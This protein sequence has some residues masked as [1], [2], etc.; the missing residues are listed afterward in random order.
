MSVVLANCGEALETDAGNDTSPKPD[1][2]SHSEST[3][4]PEAGLKRLSLPVAD[5]SAL[6]MPD[7]QCS[8]SLTLDANHVVAVCHAE[9]LDTESDYGPRLILVR[10]PDNSPTLLFHSEGGGDAYGANLAV[11]GQ[12]SNSEIHIIF[13]EFAAEYPYGTVV[14]KRHDDEVIAI[15]DYD[16]VAVDMHDELTSTLE[17]LDI[18]GSTREFR[19]QFNGPVSKSLPDGRYVDYPSG[20]I[21]F[22]YSSDGWQSYKP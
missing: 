13:V 12:N 22:M 9:S 1:T 10:D 2:A 16:V 14:F 15:G 5:V 6:N 17:I 8:Y 7:W 11:Y 3:E 21:Q 20:S 4:E 18:A 19:V